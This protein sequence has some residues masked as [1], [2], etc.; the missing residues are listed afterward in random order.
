MA[1]VSLTQ[2]DRDLLIAVCKQFTKI[3]PEKLATDLDLKVGAAS[4]R[5]SRFKA[6]T[7]GKDGQDGKESKVDAVTL[8]QTDIELLIAVCK[9]SGKVDTTQLATDL[10]LKVGAAVKRWSRF[11]AKIFGKD[12]KGSKADGGAQ[13]DD[14]GEAKTPKTPKSGKKRGRAEVENDA[15][16]VEATPSK[17]GGGEAAK[18]KKNSQMAKAD[19]VEDGVGDND[20]RLEGGLCYEMGGEGEDGEDGEDLQEYY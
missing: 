15:D 20:G 10:G 16:D 9:Q 5:W 13:A 4:K 12:G 17:K 18:G 6:K 1:T 19:D 8:N 11:K 7:V 3:E 14:K 2:G